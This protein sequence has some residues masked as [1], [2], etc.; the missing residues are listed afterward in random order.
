MKNIIK[1]FTLVGM[2]AVLAACGGSDAATTTVT[3]VDSTDT[4]PDPVVD[5]PSDKVGLG[6]GVGDDYKNGEAGTGLEPGQILSPSGTTTV[7]VNLVNLDNNNEEFLGLRDVFFISTCT[8]VGLAEFTPATVKASGVAT[9]TYKDK[10]CGKTEGTDDNIVVY[11][12]SEDAEGNIIADATARTVISVA[13]AKVGAIQ[14][15]SATPSTI[16]LSGFGTELTPSLSTLQFQ[17]VD[18]SGNAMPDRKVRF[19]LDHEFGNAALSLLE[20]STDQEGKVEVIL[21]AGDASG[22]IRVRAEVGILNEAKELIG[23]ITTLSIPIVMATSLGDQNSFTL[24][25]DVFNPA[26]WA[27]SGSKVNLTV[28]LAD[29]YQNPV[30]NGTTVYFRATGGLIDP[31]CETEGGACSVVWLSSNPRPVDGYVTVTAYTRGQGDYQDGNGNGLFDVGESFTTYGEGFIDANGNGT[32]ELDGEYQSDLDVDDDGINEFFWNKTAY[33]VYVDPTGTSP[34]SIDSSNFY[35]EFI[36][37]NANGTLD[38]NPPVAYQGVNCSADAASSASN[39]CAEQINLVRSLRLEMSYGYGANIEGPFLWDGYTGRYD[40]SKVETCLDASKY[41]VSVAWRLS[42][43]FERRNHLP[44]ATEI[45]LGGDNLAIKT[46]NGSGRI[47]SRGPV[48]TLPAWDVYWLG[49]GSAAW[50]A[51]WDSRYDLRWVN[52]AAN[53]GR[54]NA[55]LLAD[56]NAYKAANT[57][58]LAQDNSDSKKYEYLA[59]RGHII[60]A[61]VARPDTY[62]NRISQLKLTVDTLL[63]PD[64][65]ST[66]LA[67][68]IGFKASLIENNALQSDLDVSAGAKTFKLHIQ[69]L[70]GL[71]LDPSTKLVI[72]TTNGELSG[73]AAVGVTDTVDFATTST[74]QLSIGS[75]ILA[76]EVTFTLLQ[77]GSGAGE[78][79]KNS[80]TV[81]YLEDGLLNKIVDYSVTD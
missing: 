44:V 13:A 71:G 1:N 32:F 69:N 48:R 35:E 67:D 70:C 81:S 20:A 26:A 4:V 61:T 19:K 52:S 64:V 51:A 22:S 11:V 37:S 38:L 42:D 27:F 43:S 57:A 31:S 65:E 39:H 50:E 8:Q 45:A 7:N 77:D 80:F 49:D 56:R 58:E 23:T 74:A 79:I 46:S 30:L 68:T 24:S 76:T 55:D 59:A 28:H 41:N 53:I 14:Y 47:A 33:K 15:I 72:S 6:L 18:Q 17:V 10:G 5:V 54:T 12:G 66:V 62:L 60:S 75:S 78:T 2:I 9:A 29:H 3:P 73:V 40:T 34:Y 63:G 25:A 16:A 36:D 21:N